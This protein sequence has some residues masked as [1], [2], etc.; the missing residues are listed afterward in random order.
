MYEILKKSFLGRCKIHPEYLAA[1]V[2]DPGQVHIAFLDE[3][4]EKSSET[5]A[6]ILKNMIL[7]YDIKVASSTDSNP[8]SPSNDSSS[9]VNIVSWV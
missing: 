5:R 4:L 6:S 1:T 7:K 3:Y 8:A 2:L 9:Q